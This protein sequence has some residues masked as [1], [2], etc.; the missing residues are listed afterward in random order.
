M[1]GLGAEVEQG[2]TDLPA[3]LGCRYFGTLR[4][5]QEEAHASADT[6]RLSLDSCYKQMLFSL[7]VPSGWT[8]LCVSGH[9]GRVLPE[10]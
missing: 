1:W 9:G 6:R 8:L 2:L 10:R 3:T 7:R 4:N 5:S